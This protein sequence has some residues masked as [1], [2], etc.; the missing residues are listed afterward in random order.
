[1]SHRA[2]PVDPALATYVNFGNDEPSS[3]SSCVSSCLMYLKSCL[4]LAIIKPEAQIAVF[5]S[6]LFVSCCD[7]KC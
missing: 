1:M 5:V 3:L 7:D 2:L 6:V 4:I